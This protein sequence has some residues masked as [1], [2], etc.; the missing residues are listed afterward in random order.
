ML[1]LK[2]FPV[3]CSVGG[4]NSAGRSSFNFSYKRLIIENLNKEKKIELLKDLNNL[5]NGKITS[6]IDILNK[7]L[8]RKINSDLYDP[9]LLMADVM[10]VNAA[11][12]L[13]EGIDISKMYNSRQHPKGIQMTIFGVTDCL[14]NIGKDWDNEIKPY[15]NP[16]RIGV[17]SGPAIGQLDYEGM[18]G[19]LQSRKIGKRATSKHLSMSL[20]GMS[21][22]FINAYILGSLGKT[23]TV[24]GACAT[25]LYNLDLALK[26][27]KNNELDFTIVGSSEAP[28]NPE[29]TDGFLAT[30]GIAD[31]KKILEMQK[32][33]GEGDNEINY[34][35]SCRP[36]GDNAGMILGEGA[37][38]VAVT[39]LEFALEKG[40]Q[41][42]GGFTDV[43]INADGFKKSI[44]SPGIGNYLTMAQSLSNTMKIGCSLKN[45]MVVAHGTGTFQNRS[46]ES[47]VLNKVAEGFEL[48]DWKVTALKGMLGHTMGPAAGDELMVALGIWNQGIIPGI[49]TTNKL[50]QDVSSENLKFCLENT[51]V[52]K[53]TIDTIFLNAKGFGGNNGSCGVVSPYFIESLL[54]KKTLDKHKT[55]VSET[56]YA[57]EEYFEQSINGSYEL[58]Y[59]S[60][61]E[62]LD[63]DIDMTISKDRVTLKSFKDIDL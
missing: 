27:I 41:I 1:D 22:D 5:T 54:D 21:A 42:L 16:K 4:I 50:A 19:L 39:T 8:V 49:N 61:E 63:P 13:P 12:Q 51:E 46:T 36:F 15:I 52:E 2:R 55:M 29:I 23:G 57:R 37:Q 56:N 48:K 9:E 25:F 30:T 44:S 47:D 60:N 32:R 18:G 20:I 34:R 59:K 35:N 10:K 6:E 14:K 62:I 43:A 58:I 45:S 33:N 24:A 11:G 38:F 53:E 7:T 26:G 40:L 31:D 28:I 3:I 17:F